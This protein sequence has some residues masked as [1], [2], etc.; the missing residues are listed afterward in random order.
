MISMDRIKNIVTQKALTDERIL[1]VYI[2][3]SAYRNQMGPDSD[4][5]LCILPESGIFFSTM[6]KL[7]L[8]QDLA[9]E[10]NH[11]VD[12]GI[13]SSKK[14]VYAS[15]AIFKG[16]ALYKKDIHRCDNYI[17]SLTG[18]FFQLNLDRREILDA[19][20]A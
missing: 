8:G 6:D 10:M 2:L 17:A 4:I 20:R 12:V 7:A 11:N 1:A 18:M 14:H 16:Q 15:E 19:Y 5:D 3:G 13:L 9:V